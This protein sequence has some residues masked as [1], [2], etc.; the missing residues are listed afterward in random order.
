MAE[1]AC[2]LGQYLPDGGARQVGCSHLM[3]VLLGVNP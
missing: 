1:Q 3:A 2:V